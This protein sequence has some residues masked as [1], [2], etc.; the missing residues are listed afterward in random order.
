M[1]SKQYSSAIDKYTE[2]IALDAKNPVYFS[3]RAAAY[4]SVGDHQKAVDD[5]ESALAVDGSFVKAVSPLGSLS[6]SSREPY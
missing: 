4:S 1:T 5:A 2:A 3:N 6:S